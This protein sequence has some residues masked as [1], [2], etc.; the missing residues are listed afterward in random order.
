METML[1]IVKKDMSLMSPH[2]YWINHDLY[3]FRS[4]LLI[5]QAD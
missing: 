1:S 5:T 3:F 2:T 4:D